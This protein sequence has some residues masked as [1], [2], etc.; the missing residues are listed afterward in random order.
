MSKTPAIAKLAEKTMLI[1]GTATK[2]IS[3]GE[4]VRDNIN[5]YYIDVL[6]GRAKGNTPKLRK[7][8]GVGIDKFDMITCMY[9]I[10]YMMNNEDELDNLLINVSEN[11][12]DQGYFIGTCLNGDAV[13]SEMG[14]KDELKGIIDD[15]TI[16][17]IK[18]VYDDDT[19]KSNAKSNAKSK[20]K[21]KESTRKDSYKNISVGNK[22]NVFFETFGG[23]FN[24]S[25]VSI[26]YLKEKAKKHNLKLVE[27]RSFL[28]EPGNL[29][30]IY[31][32]STEDWIVNP[33]GNTQAIR[34]SNAMTTW[35]KMNCYF[36]FQKV[37]KV[38]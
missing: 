26:Q 16:F 20:D 11:L 8:E 28:E 36:M 24:E 18:K 37:R 2:N 32:A 34:S 5:K 23:A 14:G 6:Y 22:I 35:A 25:L 4:S 21:N 13:L 29:L 30:S 12:L 31:E 3:N 1:V 15:K 27:Y 9:A 33:K 19:S 17:L 38:D 7:M 10:H